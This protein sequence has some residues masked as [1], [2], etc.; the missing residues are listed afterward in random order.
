M[1][2]YRCVVCE[3]IYD[4]AVGDPDGG[5]APRNA[6]RRDSRRLGMPRLR[7]RQKQF[8]RG[9]GVNPSFGPDGGA[10]LWIGVRRI[11][12]FRRFAPRTDRGASGGPE[13]AT[14]GDRNKNRKGWIFRKS[15]LYLS[16]TEKE[17]SMSAVIN[18]T[19][20]C[21]AATCCRCC[22]VVAAAARGLS[23]E[24]DG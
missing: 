2:K 4:P 1:K 19:M 11:C 22:F 14:A 13:R 16:R 15:A 6:F 9:R 23:G 20:C 8:R 17:N 12:F 10:P 7:S 5:I 24:I 18:N 3:W 21:A